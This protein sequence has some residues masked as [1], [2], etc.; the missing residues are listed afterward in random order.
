MLYYT[1]YTLLNFISIQ[2]KGVQ[3]TLPIETISC[4]HKLSEIV[5]AETYSPTPVF[6]SHKLKR[7]E[8]TITAT[9]ECIGLL[10]K[11]TQD[12]FD[13]ISS[14]LVQLL[15]NIHT[16]ELIH[17]GTVLFT[18]AST[19]KFYSEVYASLYELL[20]TRW[21]CFKT[22]FFTKLESYLQ[23]FTDIK[24]CD[25]TDYDAFCKMK[26]EN[27]Q[28]RSFTSFIV[29]LKNKNIISKD[30]YNNIIT[31]LYDLIDQYILL[32]EKRDSVIEIIENVYLFHPEDISK[33]KILTTLTLQNYPG[34]SNKV[35][36]RCMDIL[37]ENI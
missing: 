1:M 28:R 11:L 34:L 27:E 31:T 37:D 29:H 10:N 25:S 21:D 3:C 30:Q 2:Q 18:I 20:Y 16:D 36:F 8:K 7:V 15:S 6:P 12:N 19:N 26:L 35:I 23:S 9:Q 5:G 24:T 14:K 22:L 13:S 33:L 17:I 4:I 32:E